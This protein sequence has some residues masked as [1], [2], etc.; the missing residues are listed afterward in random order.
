MQLLIDRIK[1][2]G[3]GIGTEILKVDSFLNHQVDVELTDKIGEAFAE[4]FKDSGAT[5]IM[6]VEAS[7][8]PAAISTARAMGNLPMVFAKKS[9]PNT[10]IDGNYAAPVKS[11][12]KGT[13]STVRISKAFLKQ[14]DKVLII[15][16]F[17]ATGEAAIGLLDLVRQAGA[18]CVGI[19]AVIEKE[20]QG[21]AKRLEDLGYRVESLA[22]V[23]SINNNDIKFK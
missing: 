7:G 17:L 9:A 6:T 2:D 21:G 10:M 4:I 1:K 11:F 5:K 15:D 16:D 14:E 13:L 18:K 12:T 22:I 3:V 23:E 8:I 19:G 20:W